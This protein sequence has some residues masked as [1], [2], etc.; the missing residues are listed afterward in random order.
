MVGKADQERWARWRATWGL[1]PL[2]PAVEAEKQEE[3]QR[4]VRQNRRER[5]TEFIGGF[6]CTAF[7]VGFVVL[8]MAL[9]NG[10]TLPEWAEK[11]LGLVIVVPI[12]G[13]FL[14]IVLGG[15]FD[16]R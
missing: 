15:L 10:A 12:G 6:L 7:A 3:V 9:G 4:R 13:V 8:F 14:A 1:P 16:R 11:A 2:D 5:I